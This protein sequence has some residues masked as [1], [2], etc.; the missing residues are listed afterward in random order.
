MSL[1]NR[2]LVRCIHKLGIQ[3]CRPNSPRDPLG[4]CSQNSPGQGTFRCD[5]TAK[6]RKYQQPAGYKLMYGIG[7]MVGSLTTDGWGD[8]HPPSTDPADVARTVPEKGLM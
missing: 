1:L 2:S 6:T 4:C 5:K 8:Q 3:G 7:L